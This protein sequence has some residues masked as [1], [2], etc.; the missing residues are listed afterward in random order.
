MGSD[1]VRG[2]KHDYGVLRTA[3]WE[4]RLE[5]NYPPCWADYGVYAHHC[6]MVF[7]DGARR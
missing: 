2:W 1:L 3:P 4:L 6:E 5:S 7:V